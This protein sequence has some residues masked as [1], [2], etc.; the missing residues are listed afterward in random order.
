MNVLYERASGDAFNTGIHGMIIDRRDV[1][2]HLRVRD[3]VFFGTHEIGEDGALHGM[4]YT[5]HSVHLPISFNG[6]NRTLFLAD[7]TDA[8]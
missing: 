8:T 7:K 2:D 3:L 4:L 5:S 1:I 6:F